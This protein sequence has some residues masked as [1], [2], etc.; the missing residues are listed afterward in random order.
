MCMRVLNCVSGVRRNKHM[1]TMFLG[2]TYL[3]NNSM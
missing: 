3:F 1:M 2:G